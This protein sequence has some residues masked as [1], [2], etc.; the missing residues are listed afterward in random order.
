MNITARDV[1]F[2]LV[3]VLLDTQTQ[4]TGTYRNCARCVPLRKAREDRSAERS[5]GFR[6]TDCMTTPTCL[7]A[8]L[9]VFGGKTLLRKKFPALQNLLFQT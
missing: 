9:Y 2:L 5:E 4:N 7:T 6:V 1:I 3:L 8:F